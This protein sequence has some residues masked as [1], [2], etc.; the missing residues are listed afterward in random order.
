MRADFWTPYHHFH[1]AELLDVLAAAL[2]NHVI[3]LDHRCVN[4]KE[5]SDHIEVKFHNGAIAHADL[6]VGADG[7]HSTMR[8]LVLGAESPRFPGHVACLSR[9]GAGRAPGTP[10]A[11]AERI[12]MVESGSPFCSLLCWRRS[13]L[14]QLGCRC[15]WRIAHRIMDGAGRSGRC[16][17]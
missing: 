15:A 3:R 17:A 2:P 10:G 14:R 11:R 13:P 1:R 5:H 8:E 9:A 12:M 4:I 6:V 7:I 16:T